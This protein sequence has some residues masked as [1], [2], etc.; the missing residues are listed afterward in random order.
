MASASPAALLAA[1]A[2]LPSAKPPM[3]SL[4]GLLLPLACLAAVLALTV[5]PAA[6]CRV[7]DVIK[8]RIVSADA[9]YP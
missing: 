3:Y 6:F 8:S 7:C 4:W 2:L 5:K 9:S 1:E